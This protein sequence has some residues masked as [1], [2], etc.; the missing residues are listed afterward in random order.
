MTRRL[1]VAHLTALDLAP[2]A[3]IRAAAE[4]GFDGVGLRLV[5]VTDAEPGYPLAEDRRLMR[6]T[7]AAARA[8]G[9]TVADIEF[10]KLTPDFQPDTF[11]PVLDAGAELGAR[12]VI[13]APFDDDH[14][15]LAANL[16]RLAE[17]AAPRGLGVAFE[18][19]PWTGVPD[20]ATCW[21]VAENAGEGVG[22]LAD[23]LHFDRS[24]SSLDLLAAIPA[25]RLPFA[26]ICDAP[27]HPPYETE[28][29]L[30]TARE[31]RLPPGDGEIDLRAFIAALPDETPLAVEA[32]SSARAGEARRLA[33]LRTL[34][35][36]A[37]AIVE[38]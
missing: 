28:E 3:F 10:L 15:R 13:A 4:A 18:F 11:A 32:P 31:D 9:V 5:K 36:H 29:L 19:F 16:A 33:W 34:H 27:V 2:P 22:V 24:G 1:T 23:S 7:L 17:A 8:A 38:T 12:Q 26:H 37:R 21:A 35:N 14:A 30:R 6:E 20:L 25:S